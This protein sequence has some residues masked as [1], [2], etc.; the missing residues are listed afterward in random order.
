MPG[1]LHALGEIKYTQ[2]AEKKKRVML[3]FT[4]IYFQKKSETLSASLPTFWIHQITV[5]YRTSALLV[6]TV[7]YK[8]G[9]EYLTTAFRCSVC[10]ERDDSKYLI[11]LF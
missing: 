3:S 5:F 9:F 6:F 11:I 4:F 10:L 8:I 7:L 1:P 2:L